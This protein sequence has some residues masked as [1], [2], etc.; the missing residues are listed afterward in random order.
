MKTVNYS[1]FTV[2]L[3]LLFTVDASAQDSRKVSSPDGKLVFVV[4]TVE[5]KWHYDVLYD[6]K[7]M[8]EHSP[9]G[10]KTNEGDFTSSLSFV[11]AFMDVITT[12]Y[13]QEKIKTASVKYEA[14]TLD[15]TIKNEEGKQMVLRVQVSDHD[16]A[17]RYE[18]PKW[19]DTRATVVE[20]EYTGFRF[21]AESSAFLSSMMRPMT[22]FARTAPSYES[23]YVTDADLKSTTAE[24][25]YVFPGLFK[26]G[27]NGWVLLSETGVG[28]NYNGAHLSSFT[29]GIYTMEYPQME[30]NNGFG[31]TGA[32]IGLPGHTPWRTLTVGKSLKPIVETTIP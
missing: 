25:G 32:Q 17:F 9:L 21:P 5:G 20:K 10:L 22:G 1:L 19:G 24:Y 13:K 2:F 18:L 15:Y 12:Q 8:L 4:E 14:N 7:P 29:D 27:E 23:G 31:S 30:Q 16:I 26:I 28:S 11:A 6:D 3:I